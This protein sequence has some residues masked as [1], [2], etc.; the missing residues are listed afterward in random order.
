MTFFFTRIH[1]LELRLQRCY[2]VGRH[3][4]AVHDDL[5]VLQKTWTPRPKTIPTYSQRYSNGRLRTDRWA[6][7]KK[8][9][10]EV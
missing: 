7:E 10:N 8:S 3:C 9:V 1:S 4:S 5:D 2:A 6:L